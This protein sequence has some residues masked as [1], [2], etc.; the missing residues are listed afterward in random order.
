MSHR[1]DDGAEGMRDE[2][3]EQVEDG[4]AVRLDRDGRRDGEE[5]SELDEL[6]AVD[7][8]LETPELAPDAGFV[9]HYFAEVD[10]ADQQG[11]EADEALGRG[12]ESDGLVG[13]VAQ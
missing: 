1:S 4:D 8:E 5:Q 6:V 11:G 7:A 3:G 2:L 12:D 13:P 10:A 9:L